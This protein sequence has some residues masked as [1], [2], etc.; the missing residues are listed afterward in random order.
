MA[1][2]TKY[3]Q[4]SSPFNSEYGNMAA[5]SLW[6]W[7]FGSQLWSNFL[8]CKPYL[9]IVIEDSVDKNKLN[10]FSIIN[11]KIQLSIG[12]RDDYHFVIQGALFWL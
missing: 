11:L 3:N 9:A 8:N 2:D 7:C 10:S 6:D 12:V 5:T 4:K 1:S